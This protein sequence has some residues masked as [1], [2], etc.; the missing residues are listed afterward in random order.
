M[1]ELQKSRITLKDTVQVVIYVIAIV[2]AY[3]ALDKRITT[4][5]VQ[6][7]RIAEDV[8]EIK[9]DVKKLLTRTP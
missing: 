3:S 5:E 8:R 9:A 4:L 6:Y 7:D 1:S 2:L